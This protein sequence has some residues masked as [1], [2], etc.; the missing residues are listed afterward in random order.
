MVKQTTECPH[1]EILFSDK[2][3]A[4]EIHNLDDFWEILNEESIH[5]VYE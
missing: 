3:T 5:R 2:N 4:T 1:K